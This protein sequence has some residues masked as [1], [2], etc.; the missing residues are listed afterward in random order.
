MNRLS[1]GLV[2]SGYTLLQHLGSG[3]YGEVWKATD[4]EGESVA[5]KFISTEGTSTPMR[6]VLR[7]LEGVMATVRMDHPNVLRTRVGPKDDRYLI[8]VMELADATLLDRFNLWREQGQPG[9]PR[10]ELVTY[11]EQAA[12][13]IDYL[14]DQN[15][16][17]HDI[18][19]ENLLLI[20]GLVK[21]ADFG[22]ARVAQHSITIFDSGLTLPYAP[23]EF[24]DKQAVRYASDQYS[25]AATYCRLRSGLTLFQ[26]DTPAEWMRAHTG[27][28]PDLR[29]LSPAEQPIVARAL[30]KNPNRRWRNSTEFMEHLKRQILPLEP[31]LV[32][33]DDS[34]A[35]EAFVSLPSLA[36]LPV[37]ESMNPSARGR[38]FTRS[39]VFINVLLVALCGWFLIRLLHHEEEHKLA[40]A[41][42]TEEVRASQKHLESMLDDL[43][44]A[45][46]QNDLM[47]NDQKSFRDDFDRQQRI[48]WRLDYGK[49]LELVE[50]GILKN[51]LV[52][53]EEI[54]DSC[55]EALRRSDWGYFKSV[56][57]NKSLPAIIES[58]DPIDL[59]FF[60]PSGKLVLLV[61]ERT[62]ILHD[63][64]LKTKVALHEL[65]EL[66]TFYRKLLTGASFSPV[67]P[68]LMLCY[69][70]KFTLFN[71]AT[72]KF[73]IL[74]PE[75]YPGQE[76][77]QAH[78]FPSGT[79][80]LVNSRTKTGFVSK[81]DAATGEK[82]NSITTY[83]SSDA[84]LTL[85]RDGRYFIKRPNGREVGFWTTNPVKSLK[86]D[87]PADDVLSLHLT[88]D[89]TRIFTILLDRVKVTA[90]GGK[91]LLQ[92]IPLSETP[93]DPL[94]LGDDRFL[95]YRT[96]NAIHLMDLNT[97]KQ[98]LHLPSRQR[99]ARYFLPLDAGKLFLVTQNTLKVWDLKNYPNYQPGLIEVK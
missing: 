10:M 71:M 56:M 29:Y 48:S 87:N 88:R 63:L 17:H 7:E 52:S 57:K 37:L 46:K 5:L 54:L 80:L 76:I 69:S 21:V 22:L 64:E 4:P 91:P 73:R 40:Q 53:S 82:T 1:P 36:V 97:Q 24:F 15:V 23:P 72:G 79:E 49:W 26:A 89:Q 96:L 45:R 60:H 50:E 74:E 84:D 39:M 18:K 14:N 41:E 95:M 99:I 35:S 6:N 9:I 28:I 42:L 27:E 31:E 94:I 70:G 58:K 8:L 20:S 55:P 47:A 51:D 12:A 3:G 25:L 92:E 16:L 78:Y 13:G 67:N 61:S 38:W 44:T 65:P 32:Q 59:S 86:V 62:C 34:F 77:L 33:S 11:L 90:N 85:S 30:E 98:T 68:E 19:P 66:K 43:V 75:S 83:Y 2:I 81:A 93:R